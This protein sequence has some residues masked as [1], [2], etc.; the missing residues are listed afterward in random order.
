MFTIALLLNI[1]IAGFTFVI[2][3]RAEY[4]PFTFILPFLPSS[5]PLA[6]IGNVLKISST[7]YLSLLAVLLTLTSLHLTFSQPNLVAH[8]N[9]SINSPSRGKSLL[10]REIISYISRSIGIG[11]VIPLCL[12]SLFMKWADAIC[13]TTFFIVLNSIANLL[14][15]FWQGALQIRI[16]LPLVF[17]ALIGGYLGFYLGAKYSIIQFFKTF[18]QC[19]VNYIF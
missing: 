5:I 14:G 11:G 6:L 13:T 10:V 15:P 4:F 1:L 19:I 12:I 16:R 9:S 8:Q 17:N 18:I 7:S 2:D 3:H